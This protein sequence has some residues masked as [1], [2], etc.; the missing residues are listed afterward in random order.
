MGRFINLLIS[1]ESMETKSF[2]SLGLVFLMALASLASAGVTP[3][4]PSLLDNTQTGY[5]DNPPI[6]YDPPSV[7]VP[8]PSIA[9]GNLKDGESYLETQ[10][11]MLSED[12]PVI[13]EDEPSPEVKIIIKNLLNKN[14]GALNERNTGSTDESP[15]T[16]DYDL[17]PKGDINADGKLSIEDLYY[18]RDYLF[19]GGDAPVPL[20]RAEYNG[21]G[22]LTLTDLTNWANYFLAQGVLTPDEDAPKVTLLY[23]E[24]EETKRT[25][26][27]SKNI[28]FQFEV[29][30]AS[31]INY[32]ELI[33]DGDVE[34]RIDNP[35]KDSRV[36]ITKKLSRGSYE[37]SVRCV[38][39]YGNTGQSQEWDFKLKGKDNTNDRET[40]FT[41]GNRGQDEGSTGVGYD[42][43]QVTSDTIVLNET[44]TQSRVA[45]NAW[46]YIVLGLVAA[47]V[48]IMILL[49]T[50]LVRQ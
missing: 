9:I 47:I 5:G 31:T 4:N 25:S 28:G 50:I 15:R 42:F 37:W 46:N 23:P 19:L 41:F 27:T 12:K 8:E 17:S 48:I 3:E 33:I 20:E 34:G 2:L 14:A 22:K 16:I 45:I 26:R 29:S 30:D 44:P 43:S 13:K 38:D 40:D 7:D 49:I 10:R 18:L 32:C 11:D 1:Q 39:E 6:P 36:T 24:D 21:D 35:P